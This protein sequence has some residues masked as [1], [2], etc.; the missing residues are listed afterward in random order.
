MNQYKDKRKSSSLDN[1]TYKKSIVSEVSSPIG[2]LPTLPSIKRGSMDS[3]HQDPKLFSQKAQNRISNLKL[4]SEKN[5]VLGVSVNTSS[6][7][8][9]QGNFPDK[10]NKY[11]VEHP[12]KEALRTLEANQTSLQSDRSISNTEMGLNPH[13]IFSNLIN[14]T[15]NSIKERQLL[16]QNS[17]FKFY[18]SKILF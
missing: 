8:G 18:F 16:N 12:K 2:M 5:S 15:R 14:S 7:E 6:T 1:K 10:R 3:I 4:H 11:Y 17:L 9:D 13:P